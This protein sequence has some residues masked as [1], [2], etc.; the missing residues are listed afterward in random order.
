MTSASDQA[1][2]VVA[3]WHAH[4]LPQLPRG[5]SDSV[6]VIDAGG[7][8]RTTLWTS[9]AGRDVLCAEHDDIAWSPD[10]QTVVF[11]AHEACPGQPDL[12]VVPADGSAQAAR[13][14]APDMNGVFPRFSPDGRRIAFLGSEGG[15]ATG[16]YVAECGIGRRRV[17]A[18]SRRAGSVPISKAARCS[19]GFRRSGP[20]T[21]RSSPSRS[22][23]FGGTGDIVVVKA[24]GSGQRVLAT[25]Q[26]F[27]PTWS[28]DGKRIAFHRIVDESEYWQRAAVHHARLGDQR[29]RLR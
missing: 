23:R 26:A 16:L 24:D 28:P 12:F 27:N 15:G 8:N 9:G 19:S 1:P 4:R 21:A 10:G 6:E 7:G 5:D 2:R 20:P 17:R 11:A 13:L 3:R 22:D 14:L 18:A 29:G 25:D